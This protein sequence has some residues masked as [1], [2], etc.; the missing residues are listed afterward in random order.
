MYRLTDFSLCDLQVLHGIKLDA[1]HSLSYHIDAENKDGRVEVRLSRQ[2]R[3][4]SGVCNSEKSKDMHIPALSK[5][6]LLEKIY[7]GSLFHGAHFQV[8]E[9]VQQPTQ[10]G[11][12]ATLK[13]NIDDI[14]QL[15]AGLQLALLGTEAQTDRHSVPMKIKKVVWGQQAAS[16][17]QLEHTNVGTHRFFQCLSTGYGRKVLVTSWC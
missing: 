11:T 12:Y 7:Q 3:S 1:L 4:L 6:V 9:S 16:S 13:R 15:D 10:E 2:E 14:Q 5:G 17:C 8:L